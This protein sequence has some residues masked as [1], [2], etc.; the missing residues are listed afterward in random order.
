MLAVNL[1]KGSERHMNASI[2]SSDTLTKNATPDQLKVAFIQTCLFWIARHFVSGMVL[3]F[4]ANQIPGLM[5]K[6]G[7]LMCVGVSVMLSISWILSISIFSTIFS[8]GLCAYT[9]VKNPDGFY[10]GEDVFPKIGVPKRPASRAVTMLCGLLFNMVIFKMV[11]SFYPQFVVVD[12]WQPAFLTVLLLFC[13]NRLIDIPQSFAVK[14]CLT[15]K[16][17]STPVQTSDLKE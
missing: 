2:D 11:C 6:A 7:L 12:G 10:S 14:K 1:F 16:V 17:D 3:Y 15:E 8:L 5:V 4:I 9:L 13:C